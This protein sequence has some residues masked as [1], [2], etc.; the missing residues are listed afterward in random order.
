[1]KEEKIETLHPERG[2]KNKSIPITQYKIMKAA[3]LKVLQHS[4]PT[5]TELLNKLSENLKNKFHDN[6]SW[7]AMTVK[8]DLEARKII[9]RTRTKPPRYQIKKANN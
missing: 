9:E 3:I 1:M 4:E 6:I 8:L 2:K 7:Y 5:H